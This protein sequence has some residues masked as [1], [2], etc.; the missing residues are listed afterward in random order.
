MEQQFIQLD[1]F[2]SKQNC[3]NIIE[4]LNMDNK[5]CRHTWQNAAF[6]SKQCSEYDAA[7]A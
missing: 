5:N 2:C 3:A 7:S 4:L 1:W 6:L